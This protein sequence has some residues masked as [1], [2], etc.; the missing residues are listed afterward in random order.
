LGQRAKWVPKDRAH[1]WAVHQGRKKVLS[2]CGRGWEDR[3]AHL[4][5][6]RHANA[7]SHFASVKTVRATSEEDAKEIMKERF[8]RDR[9][10]RVEARTAPEGR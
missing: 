4:Q 1:K 5:G 6:T 9:V 3:T 2:Q 10:S 7:S 8:P